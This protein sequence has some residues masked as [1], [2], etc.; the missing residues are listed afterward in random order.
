MYAVLGL[1]LCRGLCVDLRAYWWAGCSVPSSLHRSEVSEVYCARQQQLVLDFW[2]F[3]DLL[4]IVIVRLRVEELVAVCIYG[5]G[6]VTLCT[7][8]VQAIRG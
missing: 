1:L 2:C 3:R 4:F 7:Q 5:L 8:V 6:R